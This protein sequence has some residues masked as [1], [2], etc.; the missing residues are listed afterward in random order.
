M[1]NVL[2]AV[3][4]GGTAGA[5]TAWLV[6]RRTIQPAVVCRQVVPSDDVPFPE[7][8]AAEAAR[9]WTTDHGV[10]EAAPIVL[11]KLRLGWEI[12]NRRGRGARW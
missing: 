2:S 4:G 12:R 5:V 11:N 1:S 7:D 8:Q 10:D 6:A 9:R 3:I